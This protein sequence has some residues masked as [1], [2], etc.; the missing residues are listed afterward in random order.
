MLYTEEDLK[1]LID[2]LDWVGDRAYPYCFAFIKTPK[3]DGSTIYLLYESLLSQQI[4]K[5]NDSKFTDMSLFL[6]KVPIEDVPLYINDYPELA[7]WRL[8]LAK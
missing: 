1:I 8:M 5:P 6:H 2:M 7:R 3:I 4:N